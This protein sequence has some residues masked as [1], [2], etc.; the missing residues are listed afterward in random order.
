MAAV[1]ASLDTDVDFD[2]S[3]DQSGD[4]DVAMS[5]VTTQSPRSDE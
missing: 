3:A 5:S 4:T 1:R 2:D